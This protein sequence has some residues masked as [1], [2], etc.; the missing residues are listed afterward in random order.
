MIRM[1]GYPQHAAQE[2]GEAGVWFPHP[3]VL[4][5]IYCLRPSQAQVWDGMLPQAR[6]RAGGP[7]RA[8][9]VPPAR[10][11]CQGPGEG[12]VPVTALGGD[13][14]RV[15]CGTHVGDVTAAPVQNLSDPKGPPQGIEP[16]SGAAVSV[17]PYEPASQHSFAV[18]WS[19]HKGPGSDPGGGGG[20]GVSVNW[21]PPP[22]GSD[23][24]EVRRMAVRS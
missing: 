1:R 19:A 3:A 21:T 23:P 11:A 12:D 22:P 8:V 14:P 4:G 24:R 10:R 20:S 18:P 16:R 7:A 2:G 6:A 13:V 5:N 15:T 9:V 17:G